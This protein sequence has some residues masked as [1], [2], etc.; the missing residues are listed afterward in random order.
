MKCCVHSVVISQQDVDQSTARTLKTLYT[1]E[2]T[3]VLVHNALEVQ[4]RGSTS[5][6]DSTAKIWVEPCAK[7]VRKIFSS[8]WTA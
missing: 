7:R 5:K 8:T 2:G 4:V 6:G 3:G 1:L